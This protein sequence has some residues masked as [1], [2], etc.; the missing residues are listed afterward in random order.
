[1][2]TIFPTLNLVAHDYLGEAN[3][4]PAIATFARASAAARVDALGVLDT[5]GNDVLRHDYH[6]IGGEHL[7]WRIEAARTNILLHSEGFVRGFQLVGKG[8]TLRIRLKYNAHREPVIQGLKRISK[9][10]RRVYCGKRDIPRVL[11]G[12]GVAIVSTSQGL[13][14]GHE[15]SRR[16][17]GGEV[18]G[19]V[20]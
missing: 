13:M 6:P 2:P 3:G 4:A 20:W 8:K 18:L 7:G 10:S 19:Y 17:V 15:A 5:A 11:G 14:T 16:G 12:L 1:M 9:P